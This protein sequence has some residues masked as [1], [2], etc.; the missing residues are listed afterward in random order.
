M[1][2]SNIELAS[3]GGRHQ[4]FRRRL[5]IFFNSFLE[6]GAKLVFFGNGHKC[7]TIITEKCKKMDKDYMRCIEKLNDIDNEK[8]ICF[9]YFSLRFGYRMQLGLCEREIAHHYGEFR[10]CDENINSDIMRYVKGND[11]VLAI[12]AKNTDFL[13]FDL[14][15]VKYWHCGIDHLNI[16]QLETSSYSQRALRE[17]LQMTPFQYQVMMA[18]LSM[19]YLEEEKKY[20]LSKIILNRLDERS[21]SLKLIHN[22]SEFVYANVCAQNDSIDFIALQA[23]VFDNLDVNSDL[24][25]S[26]FQKYNITTTLCNNKGG[27]KQNDELQ[28]YLMESFVLNDIWNDNMIKFPIQFVD[29]RQWN[30]DDSKS[31]TEL[32]LSVHKRLM[33]IILKHKNDPTIKRKFCLKPSHD[34]ATQVVEEEP[35]FPDCKCLFYTRRALAC[36]RFRKTHT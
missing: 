18:I 8:E 9:K 28:K 24:L 7:R 19:H 26:H 21:C 20:K 16:Y 13:A 12:L 11:N 31:F 36:E 22:T 34:T 6:A 1:I 29:L 30:A 5:D 27:S 3:Y 25:E 4:I 17:C 33:G 10:M 23:Q 32:F 15:T 35:I 14:K 2:Q